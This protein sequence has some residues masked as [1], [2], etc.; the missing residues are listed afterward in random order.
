MATL[1]LKDI[2]ELLTLTGPDGVPTDAA[3]AEAAL[4]IVHNATVVIVDGRVVFAGPADKAPSPHELS[5]RTGPVLTESAGGRLVTPGLIDPHTHLVWAGDRSLEFDLR[6][7]GKSYQEIQRHGG[8]ILATVVATARASDEEL[9]LGMRARLNR[10]LVQGVT[11]C[12]VKTG[13]GLYPEAELRLLR[14]IGAARRGHPVTVSPTFLCHVPP[15][16]LSAG[17]RPDFV[18]RLGAALATAQKSGAEA[19]DVYCDAGA[20]TLAE[21][22]TL[23]RQGQAAGLGLRCHAEQFTYTGA[24]ELCARLGAASVEHLEE[25][26]DRGLAALAAGKVVA[27]LLPGAALTLRLRCPDA[28]R[29]AQAGVYVALGTDCNPGSSHSESLPLM[30]TLGCTQLGLSAAEAWLA[31]TRHAGRAL[32][33]AAADRGR[34]RIGDVGDLVIWKAERYREVCQHFGVPLVHRVYCAGQPVQLGDT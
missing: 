9:I 26:D 11:L 29:L 10:A 7:L 19:V 23:L 5:Q 31:V 2:A 4:G 21:T 15:A 16:E 33:A 25:I 34:L 3:A 27:N 28:R 14:L 30:M 24:A 18:S 17:E 22:E 32:L 13:Y 1:I 12:E 8:G 6:N 20:F